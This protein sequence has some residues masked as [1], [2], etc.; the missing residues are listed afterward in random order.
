[1]GVESIMDS[2]NKD[3]FKTLT[4]REI[5]EKDR[6]EIDNQTLFEV[7]QTVADYLNQDYEFKDL[8]FMLNEVVILRKDELVYEYHHFIKQDN[9]MLLSLY[10]YDKN[11]FDFFKVLNIKVDLDT[12]KYVEKLQSL[13][14]TCEYQC[15]EE[16]ED[17]FFKISLGDVKLKKKQKEKMLN[18]VVN[19]CVTNIS[20]LFL[21]LEMKIKETK[22]VRTIVKNVKDTNTSNNKTNKSNSNANNTNKQ[23]KRS[24]I[25]LN[26]SEKVQ[27]QYIGDRKHLTGLKK[28]YTRHVGSWNVRGYVRHYKNGKV[29]M[30]KPHVRGKKKD[31][32][33]G[34][35]YKI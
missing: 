13:Q 4:F 24:T 29:V 5:K 23:N 10:F 2:I 31:E 7:L 17:K 20:S 34:K 8:F 26:L 19:A 27:I 21:Y 1:M 30:V 33:Q 9:I 6:I 28:K 25:N 14:C 18:E 3:E 35:I 15:I 16:N 32:V 11:N 22:D 12:L